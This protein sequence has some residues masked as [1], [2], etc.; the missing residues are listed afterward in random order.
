M[1]ARTHPNMFATMKAL[2]GLWHSLPEEEKK[3]DVSVAEESAMNLSQPLMYVDRLRM[4]PPGDT[5][6]H[7]NDFPHLSNLLYHKIEL[8]RLVAKI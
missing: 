7:R 4:R 1:R 6:V 3:E 8:P 5:K 2:L